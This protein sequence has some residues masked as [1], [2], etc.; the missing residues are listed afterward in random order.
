[1][2]ESTA[3]RPAD[4]FPG[5]KEIY[6]TAN[7]N[8]AAFFQTHSKMDKYIQCAY[9][10]NMVLAEDMIG[11]MNTHCGFSVSTLQLYSVYNT[12]DVLETLIDQD[13]SMI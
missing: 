5:I 10:P 6:V 12:R 11:H 4:Y 3:N 2:T 9:C 7:D 1:M 13:A 8:A